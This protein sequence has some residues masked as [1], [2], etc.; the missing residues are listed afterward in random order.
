VKSELDNYLL[1]EQ[2]ENMDIRKHKE[3]LMAIFKEP[4]EI[5]GYHS[6]EKS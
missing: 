3:M 6:S 2:Q 5:F 1:G 4:L